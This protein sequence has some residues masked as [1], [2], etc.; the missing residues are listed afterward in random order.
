M[1]TFLILCQ[2]ITGAA[3]PGQV[4]SICRINC[5]ILA[6][7]EGTV[8]LIDQS[9]PTR[10]LVLG[11]YMPAAQH[12][13]P[14]TEAPILNL[15]ST[16]GWR[17]VASPYLDHNQDEL[18]IHL[19][20]FGP[21]GRIRRTGDALMQIVQTSLGSL[22]GEDDEIFSITSGEEHAYNDQTEIWLLPQRG[23]PQLLLKFQG[24]YENFSPL[25][26]GRKPGVMIARQTYD[27]VHAE[28]KG[29]VQEFWT[30]DPKKRSLDPPTK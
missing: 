10:N 26:R 6:V 4:D 8:R 23:V 12:L 7:Q 13:V 30:W 18:L 19:R 3:V 15:R 27:G 11:K 1:K 16:R 20:F 21:E 25:T 17:I 24:T 5:K 29:I 28:T 14:K 22:F 2:L 9:P